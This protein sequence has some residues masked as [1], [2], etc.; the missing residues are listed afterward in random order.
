MSKQRSTKPRRGD[1]VIAITFQCRFRK[2]NPEGGGIIL[3]NFR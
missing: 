1:M 3:L 2:K